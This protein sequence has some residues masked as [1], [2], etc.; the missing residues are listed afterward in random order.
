MPRR[1]INPVVAWSGSWFPLVA[2]ASLLFALSKPSQ[3]QPEPCT[4][5]VAADIA[6]WK[7]SREP[8][9]SLILWRRAQS[10]ISPPPRPIGA[11]FCQKMEWFRWPPP[12]ENW[13]FI[14][15]YDTKRPYLPLNF[16]PC[17]NAIDSETFPVAIAFSNFSSPILRFVTYAWW[18][19][20]WWISIICPLI[21]GSN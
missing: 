6:F 3:P 14:K 12:T 20:E 16:M 21:T 2:I 9:C 1:G 8:Y 18:C 4:A 7:L 11:K 19:F 13:R 15:Y 17:C 10:D 5:T